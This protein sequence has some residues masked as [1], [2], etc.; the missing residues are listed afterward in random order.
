MT[1]R[2]RLKNPVLINTFPLV[3]KNITIGKTTNIRTG[4]PELENRLTLAED[5]LAE[6]ADIVGG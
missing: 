4:V 1:L 6:L 3:K 2:E 5:A